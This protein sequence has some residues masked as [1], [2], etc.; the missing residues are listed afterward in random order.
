MLELLDKQTRLTGNQY[1][2]ITAAIL[3]DMLEFFDYYLIGYVLAFIVKPWNLTFGQSA[4]ILLSSGVGA[5][6]GAYAWGYIADRIGRRAVFM[7]TVIN[8]SAATGIL[9]LTPDHGWIFL[10]VFR[11]FVG[12]GVGRLYAVDLPLVQEF[13]PTSKRGFVGGMVTSLVPLGNMLGAVLGAY[14]TPLVGWRGLFAIGLVPALLTLLI[15]A[16]VPESPRWLARMGRHEEARQALGWALKIDPKT[17]PLTVAASET[18]PSRFLDLFHYPRSLIVSWF[19]NLGI[20]TGIYG[21]SLWSTVL[22][23]L[24]LKIPPAEA[25]FLMIF[26]NG[27]SLVGR[28]A[29]A[30][31]SE[32]IGRRLSAG[33]V[34]LGAA[35]AVVLA[36]LFPGA[37]IG[38]VSV[39]WLLLILINFLGSGGFSVIGPYATEVWPA[40]LRA[41]GMGSAYGFGGI[42]KV[43]GPAGLALIIGS[44]NLINPEAKL[45]IIAPAFFYI[46]GWFA[47][48]G[49][50]YLLVGFETKGRSFEAIDQQ[51]A[52][53]SARAG[54]RSRSQPAQ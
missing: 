21:I 45:D 4:L 9:A 13:V 30:W 44:S 53:E 16:W 47:L 54:R 8:F 42:G 41:T 10:S 52:E 38:T 43:I 17:I 6:G 7:A 22:L 27:G 5:I 34:G 46:A 25:S 19:G 29:W 20:Q 23:M 37:M 28:F 50:V 39:F 32:A 14:M 2:I 31:L 18:A 36:G 33:M 40:H 49:L 15:R 26:V 35:G 48:S 1:K 3:G 12:F 11:F 51:L 24:V